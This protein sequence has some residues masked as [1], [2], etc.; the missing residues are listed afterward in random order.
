MP[1]SFFDQEKL[2][3]RRVGST[4][5]EP[6]RKR[7]AEHVGHDATIRISFGV[8]PVPAS[9]CAN[10]DYVQLIVRYYQVFEYF[11]PPKICNRRM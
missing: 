1:I 3:Q 7:R 11:Q 2:H 9:V 5:D 10:I 6:R 8:V 4:D